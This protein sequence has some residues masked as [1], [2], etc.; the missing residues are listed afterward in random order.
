[1]MNRRKTTIGM[2][3][4]GILLI[5]GCTAQ[6]EAPTEQDGPT[7]IY[8][9][10][11]GE[12]LFNEK[13]IISGWS[14]SFLTTRGQEQAR[15]A[16]AALAEVDFDA[17]LSS[18]LGR[19]R[20]TAQRIVDEGGSGAEVEPLVE[21]RELGF[22]SFDGSVE[23]E[24]WRQ[25]MEA[26]GTPYDPALTPAGGSFWSNPAVA[27]WASTVDL[28]EQL[29]TIAR[30][31]EAGYAEDW[32]EFDGRIADARDLL[33]EAAEE[34]PGGSLLV[35]S[36]DGALRALLGHLEGEEPERGGLGNASI[37]EVVYDD[38]AFTVIERGVAPEEFVVDR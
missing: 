14:D 17:V 36:H 10:R 38:G 16:G 31:D 15:A 32:A 22:G 21:L 4:A 27:E 34:H 23:E 11:H 29:D 13:D 6:A 37:T 12:V 8:L 25:V 9:V 24:V 20:D 7:T 33:A 30:L 3:A 1:M 19:A 26:M 18:D 35:V 28:R 2:A 5:T